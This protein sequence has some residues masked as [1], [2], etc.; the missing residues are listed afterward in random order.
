VDFLEED[1]Q[2]GR[3][4]VYSDPPYLPETRTRNARYRYEY[5][6][7]DHERLLPAWSACRKTSA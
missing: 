7:A 5:S 1:F 3:V 6:V 4:L 2:H